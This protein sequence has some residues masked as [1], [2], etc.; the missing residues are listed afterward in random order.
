M[1]ISFAT[2]VAEIPRDRWGRPLIT[3]ADGGKPVPYTRVSTLA[4]TLDS[5]EQLMAWKQRMT[6]LGLGKRPDLAH[7]ASVTEPTNKAALDGIVKDAMMA[8]E[9]DRAAN[10]GTTLHALTEQMDAG[11]LE[12]IPPQYERELTAYRDAMTGIKVLAAELFVVNDHLQAAGTLDRLLTL[13]DG[14]TVVGDLKTGQSDP[15][16][17]HAVATQI[18]T[19]V[20]SHIYDPARQQRIGY[21]PDLGV[22]TEVGLLVHM[23]AGVGTCT[24]YELDL[25]TG[26]ALAKTAVAVRE[27]FKTKPI[28]EYVR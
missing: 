28:S 5:K 3:P 24:M 19:Y 7:L 13:P 4:K 16:F 8:A 22:S 10:I 12:T 21:L 2:P 14:R 18:A 17:P 26:W 27:A 23:P 15:R 25:A 11:T 9:S 1:T 20:H 6:V